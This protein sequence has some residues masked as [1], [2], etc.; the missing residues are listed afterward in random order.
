MTMF[1]TEGGTRTW[2]L[3]PIG[4]RK[5]EMQLGTGI[6]MRILRALK[7]NGPSTHSEIARTIQTFDFEKV[8]IVLGDMKSKEWVS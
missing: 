2:R 6:E 3:T 8:K 1:G 4:E 5:L 7:E